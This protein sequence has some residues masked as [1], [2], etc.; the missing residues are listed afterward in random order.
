MDDLQTNWLCTLM[1]RG[2]VDQDDDDLEVEQLD[3]RPTS[4]PTLQ[5]TPTGIS[6]EKGQAQQRGQ[7]DKQ[8]QADTRAS[9]GKQQQALERSIRA[10]DTAEHLLHGFVAKG[11]Q[12]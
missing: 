10:R 4:S 2:Q 12:Y 11:A 3:E 7:A 6:G 1:G 5:R 9:R 8:G